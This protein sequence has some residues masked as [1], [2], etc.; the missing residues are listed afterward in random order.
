MINI[1]LAFYS[2]AWRLV[3]P[4]LKRSPRVSLGWRQRILKEAAEGPFE[5]WIQ[6]ASGGESQLTGM[7]LD[8]LAAF[9]PKNRKYRILVTSGTSQGVESL[10]KCCIN[11]PV[12]SIF[13]ITV[14]YF[15]FDA[16]YL[17]QKAFDLFAPKL[18][19]ILETELWPGFLVNAKKKNIPVLLINGRMSEKSFGP[20]KFFTRFFKKYG[21]EKVLAISPIDGQRFSRLV[22]PD[23]VSL[24]NNIKFDR[25]EPRINVSQQNPIANLLPDGNP[26][27]LLGSIRREE[28]KKILD[29]IINL[30]RARPDITIGL[31]PKHI[32]RADEWLRLLAKEN[33]PAI[34]RSSFLS[35]QP[36]GSVIVWDVFG[37]LAGAYESA[38]A[39]FVGGSL[40]NLGGQNFLEPLVFGVRPIIGPYWKNFAWVGRDIIDC[41]LVQEVADENELVTGLLTAL[42]ADISR[43]QVIKQVQDF[44]E[45]RKGGTQQ[46]CRQIID[47]LDFSG[48]R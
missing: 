20:Y 39:V 6:A 47:I 23:K 25:V 36:Q 15:P 18:A 4:F 29:T 48:K 3:L 38:D 32:E 16:P 27:V 37:E 43:N 35:R 9:F 5:L 24:I 13:D 22:G 46:V 10:N 12:D 26:F 31:F 45:P 8:S 21:P 7:V 14:A 11:H 41:G 40:E 28:E 42:D 17:M 34:K 44:F 1:V 19:I 33:I 30:L 2:L